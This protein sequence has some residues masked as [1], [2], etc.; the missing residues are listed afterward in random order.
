MSAP[1]RRVSYPIATFDVMDDIS[2]TAGLSADDERARITQLRADL[3]AEIRKLG[4]DVLKETMANGV[5]VDPTA[6]TVVL[7]A[8]LDVAGEPLEFTP[9]HVAALLWHEVA[10]FCDDIG[11]GLPPGSAAALHALLAVLVRTDR[12]DGDRG[13]LFAPFHELGSLAVAS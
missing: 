1:G 5:P 7:A 6:L 4:V 9:E 12:I 11:V 2:P 3:P 8:H 13:A 10:G